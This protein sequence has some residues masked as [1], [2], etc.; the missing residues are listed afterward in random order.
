MTNK[1]A[2]ERFDQ[3]HDARIEKMFW[4]AGSLQNRDLKDMIEEMDD[5]AFKRCF[6]EI[7]SSPYFEEYKN[8]DDLMQAMVDKNK[9]GIIAEILIPIARAFNYDKKGSPTSWTT[10]GSFRPDYVYAETL[11]GLMGEI[12][13]LAGVHFKTFLDDD[14][15]KMKKSATV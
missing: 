14:K 11:E 4:I 3:A 2:L 8:D 6:P 12:E 1:E 10:S 7:A 13:K 9:F 15:K 5:K